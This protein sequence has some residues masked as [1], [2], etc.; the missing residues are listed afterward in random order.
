VEADHAVLKGLFI[1]NILKTAWDWT[2][3]KLRDAAE[4]AGLAI[5]ACLTIII[6]MWVINA[7]VNPAIN[8][9]FGLIG[10]VLVVLLTLSPKVIQPTAALTGLIALLGKQNPLRGTLQGPIWVVSVARSFLYGFLFFATFLTFWSFEESPWSFWGFFLVA[11]MFFI[12]RERHGSMGGWAKWLEW[13]Y[14]VG[15]GG[16]LLWSTFSDVHHGK[17]FDPKTGEARFMVTASTGNMD[18][19]GRSPQDC[20]PADAGE[21]FS[22]AEKGL[23]FSEETGERLVPM[24]KDQALRRSPSGLVGS[25]E[26]GL[27]ASATQRPIITLRPGETQTVAWESDGEPMFRIVSPGFDG[28]INKFVRILGT[29][30][31]PTLRLRDDVSELEVEVMTAAEAVELTATLAGAK[32]A[33]EAAQ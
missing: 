13:G 22:Y 30:S 9:V 29:R 32:A 33:L 14:I 20:R 23:C 7:W 24:T 25:A 21:D 11:I 3:T 27:S 28:P 10:L 6:L 12:W 17:A 31:H 19:E 2:E 8:G 16:L 5:F 4:A 1:M 18:S 26:D 15:C